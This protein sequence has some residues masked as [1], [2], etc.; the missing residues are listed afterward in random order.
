MLSQMLSQM[1]SHVSR[2]SGVALAS[3]LATYLLIRLFE[4]NSGRMKR[5]I[6]FYLSSVVYGISA[7]SEFTSIS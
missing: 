6:V 5:D 3:L 4:V 1:L 7:L 2:Q